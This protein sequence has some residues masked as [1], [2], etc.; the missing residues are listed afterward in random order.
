M[1]PP[2]SHPLDAISGRRDEEITRL[3]SALLQDDFQR[4]HAER[5]CLGL[6]T[7]TPLWPAGRGTPIPVLVQLDYGMQ[8]GGRTHTHLRRAAALSTWR[9]RG[10]RLGWPHLR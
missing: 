6:I 9:W 5:P 10:R 4:D 3:S 7:Q 2:P 8:A 1:P